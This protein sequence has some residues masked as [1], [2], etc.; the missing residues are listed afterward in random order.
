[1]KA[2]KYLTTRG[3]N[4]FR[5]LTKLLAERDITDEIYSIELSMLANELDR[6]ETAVEL[7]NKEGYYQRFE[8]NGTVQVNAFHTM[9]KVALEQTL[10]LGAKFGISPKD[11]K[12]IDGI[13]EK[14]EEKKSKLSLIREM[15]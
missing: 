4:Y 13:P 11:F 12:D 6:Y 1:M 5:K 2:E 8:K 7:G 3:K 14:K 15:G 9:A 10:K